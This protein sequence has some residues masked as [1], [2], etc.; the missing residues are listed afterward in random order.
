[1]LKTVNESHNSSLEAICQR[2]IDYGINLSGSTRLC[3]PAINTVKRIVSLI[4]TIMRRKEKGESNNQKLKDL[5]GIRNRVD[6][7]DEDGREQYLDLVKGIEE[8][9]ED[10]DEA[11]AGISEILKN[12]IGPEEI[13]MTFGNSRLAL[14][15]FKECP[16]TIKVLVVDDQNS[17]ASEKMILQL[18]QN[19]IESYRVSIAS[20]FTIMPKITKIVI[21]CH[22]VMADGGILGNSGIYSLGMVDATH[23]RRPKSSPSRFWRFRRS[24]SSRPSTR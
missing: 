21:S 4:K 11:Y 8:I 3:F 16:P 22:A 13:I 17:D 2:I 23:P 7:L 1:M 24:T 9:I 12:H 20:I 10:L 18:T 15:C 19:K 14:E 6:D 5:A